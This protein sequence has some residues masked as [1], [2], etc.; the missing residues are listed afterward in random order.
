MD[1]T[2][3]DKKKNQ[4]FT[5]NRK[6]HIPTTYTPCPYRVMKTKW[7]GF[8]SEVEFLPRYLGLASLYLWQVFLPRTEHL[9]FFLDAEAPRYNLIIK[10][11]IFSHR[12][13]GKYF[14]QNF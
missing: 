12:G 8:L 1:K 11:S 7:G 3:I 13:G 4:S 5:K 14:G 9:G 2:N 6:F 10:T